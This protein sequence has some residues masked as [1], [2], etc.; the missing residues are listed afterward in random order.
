MA[1]TL[2]EP[3]HVAWRSE[4]S[5]VEALTDDAA[6]PI[7]VRA[8]PSTQTR[9]IELLALSIAEAAELELQLQAAR[10][11]VARQRTRA[12]NPPVDLGFHD[13]G[14]PGDPACG[15]G[16]GPVWHHPP[17]AGWTCWAPGC[18]CSTPYHS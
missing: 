8:V 16:H 14:L 5:T 6:R 10:T 12:S 9:R 18:D 15:C 13:G 4:T 17:I 7:R 2:P 1:R 11:Y 3:T